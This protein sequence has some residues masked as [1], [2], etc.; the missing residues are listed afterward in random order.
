MKVP[1]SFQDNWGEPLYLW[2]RHAFQS[3]ALKVGIEKRKKRNCTFAMEKFLIIIY[4]HVIKSNQQWAQ[5]FL[6]PFFCE[7]NNTPPTCFTQHSTTWSIQNEVI[8]DPYPFSVEHNDK[9]TFQSY[10][11]NH[12]GGSP[13]N[14]FEYWG[15]ITFTSSV[16]II[17]FQPQLNGS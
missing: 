11:M 9:A 8:V 16:D 7:A 2:F 1:V 12:P 10:S 15:W 6:A 17:R 3:L 14:P 4:L 5:Q 13:S